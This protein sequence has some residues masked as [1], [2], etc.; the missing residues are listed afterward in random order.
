MVCTVCFRFDPL[1]EQCMLG[2]S[3]NHWESQPIILPSS[4][5]HLPAPNPAP[6]HLSWISSV[7]LAV[8]SSP[9]EQSTMAFTRSATGHSSSIVPMGRTLPIEASTTTGPCVLFRCLWAG[10]RQLLSLSKDAARECLRAH[11]RI[12]HKKALIITKDQEC[13][14]GGCR[15]AS[16]P[17]RCQDRPRDHVAHVEDLFNH[18]FKRHVEKQ[19]EGR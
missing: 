14:W 4:A 8:P 11:F 3:R 6:R 13:M 16:R 5:L 2:L 17:S 9:T 19:M 18:V 7:P 10:C 12:E 15:C 1:P